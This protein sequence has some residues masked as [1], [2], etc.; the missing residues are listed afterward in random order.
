MDEETSVIVTD[1]KAHCLPCEDF[2]GSYAQKLYG[3]IACCFTVG[4]RE[5]G[6][7]DECHKYICEVCLDDAEG[8]VMYDAGNK[9]YYLSYEC[10][11][12]KRPVNFLRPITLKKSDR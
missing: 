5:T 12:C 1:Q 10:F 4:L 3:C 11:G 2:K 8:H 7:A 9:R 6:S